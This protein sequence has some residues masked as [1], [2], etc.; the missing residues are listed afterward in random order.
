MNIVPLE[1]QL[2]NGS[3]PEL[4]AADPITDEPCLNL[5]GEWVLAGEPWDTEEYHAA[6]EISTFFLPV[7]GRDMRYHAVTVAILQALKRISMAPALIKARIPPST[8]S[9]M[10][11]IPQPL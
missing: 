4:F 5:V 3:F 1:L 9:G 2:A 6:I 10:T 8:F 11:C 7:Q